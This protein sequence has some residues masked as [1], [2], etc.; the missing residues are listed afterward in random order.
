MGDCYPTSTLL[1]IDELPDTT[2]EDFQRTTGLM[3]SEAEET[4]TQTGGTSGRAVIAAVCHKSEGCGFEARWGNWISSICLII[5][6]PPD[7]GID[8][9]SNGD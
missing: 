1:V 9:V 6:A 4:V 2:E 8:S 3:P 7:G 5:P